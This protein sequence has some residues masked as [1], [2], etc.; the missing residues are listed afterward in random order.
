GAGAI[1]RNQFWDC[2]KGCAIISVVIG[3][4]FQITHEFVYAYHLALF[5]FVSGWFYNEKKYGDAPELNLAA[6]MKRN[7]PKFVI[8]SSILTLLH[9][10]LQPFLGVDM[11]REYISVK[12]AVIYIIESCAFRVD[13]RLCGSMW[14]LPQIVLASTLF[15]LIVWFSRRR[16][17]VKRKDAVIILLSVLFGAVG[18]ILSWRDLRIAGGLHLEYDM[19]AMPIY[20]AAYYAR[21]LLGEKPE[22]ALKLAVALPCLGVILLGCLLHIPMGVESP[23]YSFYL[24]GAAGIYGILYLCRLIGRIPYLAAVLS[25]I[26]EY[27]FEIM[28]FNVIIY[29]LFNA[30]FLRIPGVKQ[31]AFSLNYFQ[32]YWFIQLPVLLGLPCI[33]GTVYKRTRKALFS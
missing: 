1:Q 14:F 11:V 3:H 31:N 28:A 19:K 23:P 22:K 7:W 10:L 24:L 12:T 6:R 18:S 29:F 32:Q 25:K 9:V 8:Y 33:I 2:A 21:K 26:G 27:S 13:D 15:G 5:Y 30:V 16:F 20:L 4:G 17:A